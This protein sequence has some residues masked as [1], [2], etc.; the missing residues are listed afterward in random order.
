VIVLVPFG[1]EAAR[2][3]VPFGIG[4]NC[5]RVIYDSGAFGD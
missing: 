5:V 4:G 1:L 3:G 2:V